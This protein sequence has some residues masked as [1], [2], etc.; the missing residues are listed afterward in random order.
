MFSTWADSS[1]ANPTGSNSGRNFDSAD[2]IRIDGSAGDV[3]NLGPDAGTWLLATGATGI[4]AGYT[5]YSH[6]TSGSNPADDENA[7]LF[8]QTGITVNGIGT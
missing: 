5:A 2:A 3:L 1:S 6:V 4:P 8:V 7:Y